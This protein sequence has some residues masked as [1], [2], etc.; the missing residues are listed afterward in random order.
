MVIKRCG[1]VNMLAFVAWSSVFAILPL[2]G[3]SLAMEGIGH[4]HHAMASASWQAWAA[5]LWQAVGNTLFGYTAWNWLLARY[6]ASTV[7]P[8]SLGVPIFGMAA[9]A[10][11]L[12]EPLPA[13]KFLAAALVIAGLTLTIMNRGL[14]PRA[15][16]ETM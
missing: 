14:R 10:W 4:I 1:A 13:W 2:L 15:V 12:G 5:V 6:P 7:A 9:S 11:W 3:L 8:L 16:C